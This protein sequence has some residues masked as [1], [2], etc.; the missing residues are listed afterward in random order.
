MKKMTRIT[1][2]FLFLFPSL[3]LSYSDQAI[4]LLVRAS[5][6]TSDY[7]RYCIELATL[8]NGGVVNVTNFGWYTPYLASSSIDPCDVVNLNQSLPHSFS[9]NSMVILY[10]HNCKMTEHAWNVQRLFGSQISLM[11]ITNRTDTQYELTL[12]ATAMPVS[13][14]VVVFLED[15]FIKLKN[16]YPDFNSMR[17]SIGF[18]PNDSRKFRPAILLMFLL[19][20]VILLCGNFWAADEFRK[21]INP[22]KTIHETPPDTPETP[23]TASSE[24]NSPP[25]RTRRESFTQIVPKRNSV[26]PSEISTS[27]RTPSAPSQKKAEPALIPLTCCVIIIIICFAVGWLLLL[28]FF[29]KVMIYILQGK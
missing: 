17:L 28:Y 22:Q 7:S 9:A 13:I 21:K 3:V 16:R 15:D 2:V 4:N 6:S 24:L 12:N 11:I 1:V 29:P 20:F 19:V 14:P 10:E 26:A 23:D 18:P 27:E 8:P 25:I 5:S